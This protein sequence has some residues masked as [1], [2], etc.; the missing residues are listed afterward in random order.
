MKTRNPKHNEKRLR[1][2]QVRPNS[3]TDC[4]KLILFG[5]SGHA[6]DV[7]DAASLIGYEEFILV[8]T[9]GSSDIIGKEALKETDF[10]PSV[11][12]DWDCIVA[13][14]NIAHRKY[15]FSKYAR[16][17]QVSII[18]PSAVVSRSASI[19]SGCYVG[20][21]AYIGPNSVLSEACIV[22]THTTIGHDSTIGAYSQIGPKVCIPGNVSIGESVFVGAGVVFNNGSKDSPL[23]IPDFTEIGM[24]CLIT[25]SIKHRGLKMIPKPNHISVNP[26]Q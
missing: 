11:Y 5:A 13:I 26:D 10:D 18:S 12:T 4:R 1:P 14:G 15:F 7:L 2:N 21:F 25:N 24:G 23:L 8:T 22:N 19:G 9:D 16:M 20:A 3:R 6:M 17:R